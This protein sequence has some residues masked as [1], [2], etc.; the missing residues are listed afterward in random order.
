MF[1][2]IDM[3]K[4]A[5]IGASYLQAPLIE[6]AKEMDCETHVFAWAADDVG[7]K[8]A[9]H[10]YPI[11][12][13]EKDA[14]LEKCREIGI[15]GICTIA[16][17]LAAITVNYVAEKMGLT[18]NTMRCCEKSTNKHKMREAF[19]AAGDPSPRSVLIGPKTD[20]SV[21]EGMEY[22]LIVKP[23]DRSGSRGITEVKRPAGLQAAIVRAREQSFEKMALVEEFATGQEYSVECISWQGEHH[24]LQITLKYTTGAPMYI[25]TGHMEPA[26]LTDAIREKVRKTVFHA[27]DTLEIQ[28]GAS[29]SELKIDEGGNI[30]LIEIGGRMGGDCIGSHLVPLSTGQD[31][32]RMVVQIALGQAPDLTVGP[33]H[34]ACGVRFVFGPQDIELREALRGAP[35][36]T[37]VEESPI[38]PMDHIVTDSSTR[39][40]Y[41]IFASEDPARI[42]T[43]MEK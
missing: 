37:M 42:C 20:L 18:G 11:S 35:G 43:W 17:D 15:D 3:K 1:E 40:G 38:D 9:D 13:V 39:F 14:I 29:H 34:T 26:P 8:I 16:S 30:R 7:E 31:F 10:F 4:L 27:L 33:H 21:L 22:P 32:V 6:K 25:E 24:L 23:T 12:I 41:Y 36:I 2:E 5:I 28:N 19:A